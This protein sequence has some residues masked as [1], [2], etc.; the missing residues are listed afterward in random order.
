MLFAYKLKF[1]LTFNISKQIEFASIYLFIIT[2][3]IFCVWA[4]SI[5]H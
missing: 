2:I 4:S 1:R 3:F 5:F